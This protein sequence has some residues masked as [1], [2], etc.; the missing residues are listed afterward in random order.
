MLDRE[1]EVRSDPRYSM[2]PWIH[3]CLCR[4]TQQKSVWSGPKLRSRRRTLVKKR[5]HKEEFPVVWCY[6]KHNRIL[7]CSTSTA[8]VQQWSR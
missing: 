4:L 1:S 7:R 8:Q 5:L 3:C 6:Q 2:G